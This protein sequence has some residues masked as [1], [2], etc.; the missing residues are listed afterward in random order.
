M[1]S[2]MR[3]SFTARIFVT[4]LLV[5]LLP[6]LVCSVIMMPVLIQRSNIQLQTQSKE[7]LTICQDKLTAVFAGFLQMGET[8]HSSPIIRQGLEDHALEAKVYQ[9]FFETTAGYYDIAHFGLFD[10]QGA[11]RYAIN[12]S[13][14]GNDLDKDWGV[15]F[16]AAQGEEM[17][18][19]KADMDGGLLAAQPI[20]EKGN[21][22]GYFVLS[23]TTN[24]LDT[25]FANLY[26]TSSSIMLLD[27]QF[28]SIYNSQPTRD[29]E[30]E[31]LR[32]QMLNSQALTGVDGALQF[33]L[34]KEETSGLYL[35]LARPK[36]FT[37]KITNT[38]YTISILMGA[39][40]LAFCLWGAWFLSRHLSQP[41]R[42]LSQAMGRVEKGDLEVRISTVREDELGQLSTSFNRMVERYRQNLT[43]TVARQKELNDT[44]LRM[45]H[46]QLN[47]HF[48]YN[49]LDSMKWLGVANNVPK[50]SALAAD[51]AVLLRASISENDFVP[52]EKELEW[53]ERYIDIQSIRFEDSFTCEID[54]QEEFQ[55]CMVPKLIL[56]PLVENAVIHGVADG[57]NGYIKLWAERTE[58]G[59]TITVSDNG[60]GMTKALVD[61]LNSGET[62]IPHGHLG[63]YNVDSI[64]RL[65][66]GNQYGITAWS[67]EGR[68]SKVSLRL[69]FIRKE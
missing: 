69:P 58:K 25:L 13:S 26:D 20:G 43:D 14:L 5:A 12:T 16:K 48:L 17:V 35:V 23:M 54:V 55:G 27:K 64:L 52:L 31:V 46:A 6:I 45:M 59:F 10:A 37:T 57:K 60:C 51:L 2:L 15:L 53:I 36:T 24:D 8:I 49:T 33:H 66:Y 47:P 67:K 18:F 1:K 29:R 30:V 39:L 61:D 3:R 38:F 9:E 19:Q 62:R 4:V 42:D 68:G 22:V 28:R 56:Q 50:V 32:N 7:Q 34:T 44:Q 63:L 41:V 21:H 40:C 65:H 11:C